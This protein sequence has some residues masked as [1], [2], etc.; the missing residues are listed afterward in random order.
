MNEESWKFDE[1]L[2]SVL[3]EAR[4]HAKEHLTQASEGNATAGFL[5]SFRNIEVDR[6]K[7]IEN[8]LC[9]TDTGTEQEVQLLTRLL[10][11]WLAW[12]FAG[13]PAVRLWQQISERLRRDVALPTIAFKMKAYGDVYRIERRRFAE[14]EKLTGTEKSAEEDLETLEG[15]VTIVD[16]STLT[17]ENEELQLLDQRIALEG[18]VKPD[19]S[20][21][22]KNRM[23]DY[24]LHQA[25]RRTAETSY[26]INA[27]VEILAR[28]YCSCQILRYVKAGHPIELFLILKDDSDVEAV[29]IIIDEK[30]NKS[31]KKQ[32]AYWYSE[33]DAVAKDVPIGVLGTHTGVVRED[34]QWLGSPVGRK[35]DTRRLTSLS[36]VVKKLPKSAE[37]QLF[38]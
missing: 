25:T 33:H 5:A 18:E 31:A 19:A 38:P 36:N 10:G 7:R 29:R 24:Y 22:I 23:L 6:L 1:D 26:C 28:H 34:G 16:H 9:D 12:Y 11:V 8:A 14:R 3:K 4:A 13:V 32:V 2:L 20:S 35:F 37:N 15:I 27:L 17:D 30:L 21:Q